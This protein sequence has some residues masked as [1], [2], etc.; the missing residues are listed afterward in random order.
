MISHF[1]SAFAATAQAASVTYVIDNSHT[2]LHF[3]YNHFGFSNQTHKFDKTR[4]KVVLDRA[5]KAGS[6]S[7]II[8]ATS[9]NTGHA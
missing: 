1:C 6:V 4:G 2:Y 7:V 8:D 9:V 5:G 3:T